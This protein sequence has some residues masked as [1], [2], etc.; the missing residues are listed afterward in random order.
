[1]RSNAGAEHSSGLLGR[2]EG[3]GPGGPVDAGPSCPHS[4]V[5][6]QSAG[7]C[8]GC[9]VCVRACV[10]AL[11]ERRADPI[12]T[13]TSNDQRTRARGR[14]QVGGGRRDRGQAGRAGTEGGPGPSGEADRTMNRVRIFSWSCGARRAGSKRRGRPPSRLLPIVGIADWEPTA[15]PAPIRGS[16]WRSATNRRDRRLGA[17]RPPGPN[18]RVGLEVSSQV[19]SPSAILTGRRLGGRPHLPA[20]SQSA[21][22]GSNQNSLPWRSYGALRS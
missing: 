4:P 22:Q 6:V 18:Q 8:N 3:S 13:R 14:L 2:I 7:L 20:A 10:R 17:D 11:H 5:A 15:R 1:M 16:G 9:G 19:G 12:A 21:P